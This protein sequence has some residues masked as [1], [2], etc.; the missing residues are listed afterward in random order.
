[1]YLPRV[2]IFFMNPKGEIQKMK[3]MSTMHIEVP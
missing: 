2:V 3:V 1:M